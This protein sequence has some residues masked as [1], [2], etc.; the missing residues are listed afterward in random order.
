MSIPN[1]IDAACYALHDA[2]V[3][4][5]SPAQFLLGLVRFV[6]NVCARLWLAHEGSVR[7][8]GV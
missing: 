5:W 2:G 6:H 8:A 7:C 4:T 1:A 3:G